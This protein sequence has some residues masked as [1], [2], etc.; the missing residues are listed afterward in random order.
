MIGYRKFQIRGTS[1]T[2]CG[3][4]Q[5]KGGEDNHENPDI[6]GNRIARYRLFRMGVGSVAHIGASNEIRAAG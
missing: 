3:M 4:Q 5:E 6:G 1:R 2:R